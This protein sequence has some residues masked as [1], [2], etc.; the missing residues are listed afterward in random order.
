MVKGSVFS[1]FFPD[2]A[3][4]KAETKAF[5]TDFIQQKH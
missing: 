3:H 4:L 1:V 2:I 5:D